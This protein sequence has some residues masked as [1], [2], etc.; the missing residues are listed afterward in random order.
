MMMMKLAIC[1]PWTVFGVGTTAVLAQPIVSQVT[2]VVTPWGE[3]T[4]MGCLT[5]ILVWTFTKTIPA[6]V[7]AKISS[8]T[9]SL[10]T[11]TTICDRFDAS[12]ERI[13]ARYEAREVRNEEAMLKVSDALNKLAEHCA[14]INKTN[15]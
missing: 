9:N 8:E 6:L 11:I 1:V 2:D 14:F 3:W 15:V 5:F 7:T 10:L 4:A 13:T 12:L